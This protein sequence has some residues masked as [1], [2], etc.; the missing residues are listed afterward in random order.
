MDA[1]LWV[2]LVSVSKIEVKRGVFEGR[3]W[4]AI[5]ERCRR[6]INSSSPYKELVRLIVTLPRTISSVIDVCVG[7]VRCIRFSRKMQEFLQSQQC[8]ANDLLCA[9]W[10]QPPMLGSRMMLPRSLCSRKDVEMDI[11]KRA[12][13]LRAILFEYS[14]S[15]CNIIQREAKCL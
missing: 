8:Y 4:K 9:G 14:C 2:T 11:F 7:C 10:L 6:F 1:S 15:R 3:W 13:V 12:A 5:A